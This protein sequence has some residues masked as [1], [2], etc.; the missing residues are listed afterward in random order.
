MQLHDI[1]LEHAQYCPRWFSSVFRRS[2]QIVSVC[3]HRRS[4]VVLPSPPR[5]EGRENSR[6]WAVGHSG[7]RC[8]SVLP[9]TISTTSPPPPRLYRIARTRSGRR[10]PT[11]V[12]RRDT[13]STEPRSLLIAVRCDQILTLDLNRMRFSRVSIVVI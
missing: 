7:R 11:T 6:P 9:A 8:R 4:F 12:A 10:S 5:R 13:R 2:C 1:A 3:R